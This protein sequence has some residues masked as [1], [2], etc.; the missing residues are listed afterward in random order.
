MYLIKDGETRSYQSTNR[1]GNYESEIIYKDIKDSPRLNL[2]VGDIVGFTKY[3][4]I[5]YKKNQ[6][7]VILNRFKKIK[8]CFYG[9]YVD[10]G[11][12]F[13]MITGSKKGEIKKQF[14][15]SGS[16]TKYM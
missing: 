2:R 9:R 11:I 8:S 7:A 6:F 3:S 14:L 16:P 1:W 10:Y 13:M 4:K 5:K 12:E 15:R